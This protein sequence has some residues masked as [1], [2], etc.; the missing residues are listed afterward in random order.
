MRS[1][2]YYDDWLEKPYQQMQVEDEAF[3]ERVELET[4]LIYSSSALGDAVIEAVGNIDSHSLKM[5]LRYLREE[6]YEG[7][8]EV[9][10][11]ITK[12]KVL[13]WAEERIAK[14]DKA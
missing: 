13:T 8:G 6:D 12:V 1:D 10:V 7:V 11:S 9:I 5:L 2:T 3:A 14:K 4:E